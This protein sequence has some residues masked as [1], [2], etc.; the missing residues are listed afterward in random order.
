MLI[1]GAKSQTFFSDSVNCL[2]FVQLNAINAQIAGYFNLRPSQ[3][4]FVVN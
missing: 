1:L 3:Q 2:V 4:H